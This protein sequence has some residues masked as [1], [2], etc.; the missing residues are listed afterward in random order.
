MVAYSRK[1]K[2]LNWLGMP[3]TKLVFRILMALLLFS[4]SRWLVYLFNTE[5]FHHLTLSQAM[6]LYV[7]GL[8]FDLVVVAYANALMI[9]YFC[10]PFKF[11]YNKVLQQAINV[12]Y[13][14]VNAFI[15]LLNMVD[16]VYFGYYGRQISERLFTD[17][18]V[19]KEA[20][21]PIARLMLIDYWHILVLTVLFVL[22]LVVV[23]KRTLLI[24]D[25]KEPPHPLMQWGTLLVFAILT[26]IAARGGIQSKPIDMTT[27]LKY[28]DSQSLSIVVNT[29]FTIIKSATGLEVQQHQY[30]GLEDIDFTPIHN[31]TAANRF[32]ADSLGY[33]PNL[34]FVVLDGIGQ[35]VVGYYNPNQRHPLTPFLDTLLAQSLAFDGRANGHRAVE[36]LPALFSG[37]PPLTEVIFRTSTGISNPSGHL[38]YLLKQK[39]YTLTLSRSKGATSAID[40]LGRPLAAVVYPSFTN[41][42]TLPKESYLWSSFEKNVYRTDDALRA[43]FEEAATKPWF[44]S[45]LFVITADHANTEHYLPE[46][47]NLWGMYAIPVAFH[48]PTQIM[49]RHCDELAQQI[50]LNGSILS[51]MGFNDTVFSFGRNLFDS[52]TTPSFIAY[53]NQ[54]YQYSDGQYLIQSDGINTIGVFNI[55]RDRQ[56]ND[57]LIDRIQ[58]EDI[59]MIMKKTIQEYEQAK[60]TV[61]PQP[62]SGSGR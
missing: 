40:T 32:V 2:K 54:T 6:R 30:S 20:L 48:W 46:Y 5:Y 8:R 44:D 60:D 17:I 50:D 53:I 52:L 25:E 57:N 36:A 19:F 62:C 1:R 43:F 26:P 35:E 3:A 31:T 7:T 33:T 16:V 10:L 9:L 27:A 21:K 13:V 12:Y 37:I 28:A 34:V 38:G 59:A 4:V 14:V 15:I 49:P 23:S 39:G 61:Y 11:I 56:L 47:S 22:V 42:V 55:K 45:T 24:L 51:A 29:P 41:D 58:C 18:Q